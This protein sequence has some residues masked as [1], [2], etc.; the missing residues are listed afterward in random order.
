VP[1]PERFV[2][3]IVIAALYLPFILVL[4]RAVRRGSPLRAGL[5]GALSKVLVL[6]ALFIGLQLQL[7]PFVLIV[8]LPVLAGLFVLFEVFADAAYKV[9]RNVVLIAAVQAALLA[10]TTAAAMPV[11]L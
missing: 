11:K 10:W 3:T 5:L 7:L 9:G 8:I 2:L 6:V 1:T 4:E